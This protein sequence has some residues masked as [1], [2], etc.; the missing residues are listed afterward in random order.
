MEEIRPGLLVT[1]KRKTNKVAQ[2][3]EDVDN[4]YEAGKQA[5][6]ALQHVAEAVTEYLGDLKKKGIDVEYI[7]KNAEQIRAVF[8]AM[9]ETIENAETKEGKASE[10]S[11]ATGGSQATG[12][13]GGSE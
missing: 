6:Y 2:L 12:A 10:E 5:V 4:K 7:K 8:F 11:G 3:K 13:H 1:K 9:M